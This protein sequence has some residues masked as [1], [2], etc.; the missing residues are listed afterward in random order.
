MSYRNSLHNTMSLVMTTKFL[1]SSNPPHNTGII[2]GTRK[3]G[4]GGG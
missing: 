1:G 4:G 2:I 3:G